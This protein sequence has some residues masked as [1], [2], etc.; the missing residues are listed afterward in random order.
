[1]HQD[2]VYLKCITFPA[3]VTS[4]NVMMSLVEV[5]LCINYGGSGNHLFFKIQISMIN[6]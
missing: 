1:M 2:I 4:V 5:L 3:D 6:R